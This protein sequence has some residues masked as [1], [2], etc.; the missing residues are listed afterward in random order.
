MTILL[1]NFMLSWDPLIFKYLQ[2]STFKKYEFI[3]EF[4]LNFNGWI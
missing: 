1:M 4:E 2:M 3:I